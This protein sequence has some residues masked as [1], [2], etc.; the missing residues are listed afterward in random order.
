MSKKIMFLTLVVS[1]AFLAGTAFAKIS[2]T[3]P[4]GRTFE[5]TSLIG[6][7]VIGSAGNYI[8][9]ISDLVIDQ[10]NDRIALVVLSDV[11]GL[12]G[13]QVAIPY[14]CLERGGIN[15]F[16]AHFSGATESVS[17]REDPE[18][19]FLAQYPADSPLYRISQPIDPNWVAEVYRTY[20]GLPY[21]T[22][23]AER[24]P[25]DF[26]FYQIS[27]LMGTSVRSTEGDVYATVKDLVVD[28][29]GHINL[30]IL[31]DVK[32]RDHHEMAIP[33]DKLYRTSEGAFALDIMGDQLASA[34]I[35][36]KR[37]MYRYGYA[38]RVDRFF[39][40]Q[41]RWSDRGQAK[42]LNPYRWGGEAQDF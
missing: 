11:P 10:A 27:K 33:F 18:L 6:H 34:P 14:G 1:V 20:E 23:K 8:G 40:L 13:D 39:S 4:M 16:K 38:D 41:P 30:V 31:S 19:S 21:W 12:G 32:G 26:D 24:T 3:Y 25:L 42:N 22:Q 36:H 2:T 9:Q 28:P 29:T 37:D 17:N 35:F 15:T 5:S 7:R